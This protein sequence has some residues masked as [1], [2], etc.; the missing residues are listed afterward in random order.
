MVMIF[1][2]KYEKHFCEQVGV[3]LPD[4]L[5]SGVIITITFHSVHSHQLDRQQGRCANVPLGDCSRLEVGG[6]S[7]VY[8]ENLNVNVN[9]NRTL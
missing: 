5:F 1:F 3:R 9:T 4:M 7:F 8:K 2:S 6:G